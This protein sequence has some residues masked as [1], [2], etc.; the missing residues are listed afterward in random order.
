M[1]RTFPKDTLARGPSRLRKPALFSP[2]VGS[3]F[4]LVR[5]PMR[6]GK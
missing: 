6:L 1:P 4:E 5:R 2:P 3:G